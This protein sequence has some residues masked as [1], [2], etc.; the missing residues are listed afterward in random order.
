MVFT[1]INYC[2]KLTRKY[3]IELKISQQGVGPIDVGEDL[4]R[5]AWKKIFKRI[6]IDLL[7]TGGNSQLCFIQKCAIKLVIYSRWSAYGV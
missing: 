1:K 2:S 3:G 4:G 5:I 7:Y 6:D